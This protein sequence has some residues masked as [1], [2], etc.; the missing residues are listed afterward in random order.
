MA[1]YSRPAKYIPALAWYRPVQD[2]AYAFIR[3][4]TGAIMIPHGVDRIF[5][6]G[7]HTEL[8]G[9]LAAI[10][11]S[12]IG[13]FEIVGGLLIAL[14][15]LTRPVALL[16]AIEWIGIALLVPIKPGESWIMAGE[17]AHLPTLIAA[18]CVAFVLRGGGQYSLDRLLRKE[19]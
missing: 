6:S 13:I 2:F 4:C 17:S 7:S 5:Y 15:L 8:G 16:A 11:V 14:G 10:P 9:F 18:L 19:C 3:F 1:D 12:A